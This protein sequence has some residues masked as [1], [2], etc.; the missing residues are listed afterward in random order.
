MEKVLNVSVR[1]LHVDC[2]PA[3]VLSRAR[4]MDRFYR[5]ASGPEYITF[6]S[7]LKRKE[8]RKRGVQ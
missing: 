5:Q 2:V 6:L 4:N 1:V 3:E 8:G 7:A